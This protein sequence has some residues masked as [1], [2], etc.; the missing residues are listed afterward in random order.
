MAAGSVVKESEERSGRALPSHVRVAVIGSGFGGLGAAVRLRRAGVT[1]FVILERREALGGTWHDNTYPGCACDIPS[2]LYSFSF[3]PNPDWPRAYAPQNEIREYLEGVADTFGLRQHL[4]L[5]T[6]VQQM[7]WDADELQWR[8][9]TSRGTLTADVVV[10]ATGPLSEPRQLDIP[11]LD[12]FE[13]KVMHSATWDHDYDLRGKRVA[14]VGTGA[15]AIQIVPAIQPVVDRLTVFQRTPAWVVPR[16]DRRVTGFERRLHRKLPSTQK[17]ARF[18]LWGALELGTQV[19]A[20]HPKLLAVLEKVATGHM[21]RAVKDPELRR[22]LTPDYR[23]GC[24]RTLFSDD[25]YPALAQ[26]N[27]DVI[28]SGLKEIRGNTLVSSDGREAEVD[29]IVFCSGFHVADMPVAEF[30]KGADGETLAESWAED[31]MNALRGT[32]TTGFPN[33][34]FVIGPN[35]GLGSSSMILI[36]EAQLN[37]LVDYVRKLD[38]LGGGTPGD[39]VALDVRPVAQHRYNT[40][41]RERI[42]G[43]VWQTGCTSWYLD[44][45]GRPVAVWPGTTAEFRKTTREVWLEEYEVLRAA[46]RNGQERP[47]RTRRAPLLAGSTKSAATAALRTAEDTPEDSKR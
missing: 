4:Q 21:K 11:G 5:R 28:D 33:F 35:T 20:N 15:S 45:E 34:L 22:K 2:H 27:T 10:S 25:Y 26:P 31:G 37:Y 18:A 44:S 1:D 7:M 29:A 32:T 14:V 23:I 17:L 9:E 8:V 13:G 36:I 19:Y 38:T 39:R 40:K 42:K 43:S 46:P 47:A 30:V 16:G 41:L 24:K 3:A 12:T 6:E